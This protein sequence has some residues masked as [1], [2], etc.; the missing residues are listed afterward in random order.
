[1]PAVVAAALA[2]LDLTTHAGTLAQHL[3]GGNKRRLSLALA[4]V[5]APRVVAIDE[6]TTGVVSVGIEC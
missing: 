6:P 2:A 3:S 1:M 5:G 4:Y